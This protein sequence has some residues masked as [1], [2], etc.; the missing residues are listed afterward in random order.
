MTKQ[1]LQEKVDKY[2]D[3]RDEFYNFLDSNL[4]KT[5]FDQ[6]DFSNNQ[7]FDAKKVYELFFKLDYQARKLRPYIAKAYNLKL[8]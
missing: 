5:K 1:N 2:L 8:E 6:F 3:V 4:E 7:I